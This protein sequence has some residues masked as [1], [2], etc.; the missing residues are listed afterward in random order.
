M[1]LNEKVAYI[2]GLMDGMKLN[3]NDDTVKVLK[4]IVELLERSHAGGF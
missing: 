2:R 4:N 3:E 1:E